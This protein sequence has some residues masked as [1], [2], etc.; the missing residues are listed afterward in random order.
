MPPDQ[1]P[2]DRSLLQAYAEGDAEAFAELTRRTAGMV[3]AT[4][5]RVLGDAQLA[6]DAS[7][8]TFLQLMRSC[9][10]VTGCVGAWLHRVATT[11]ALDLARAE[12]RRDERQRQAG[13]A[14]EARSWK[15]IS[16]QVDEALEQLDHAQRLLLVRH[17]L[18]GATQVELARELTSSQASI[19]RQLHE[20]LEAIRTRLR[21]RGVQ[22]SAALLLQGWSTDQAAPVPRKLLI[23]LGKMALTPAPAAAV[24]LPLAWLAL[25]ALSLLGAAS[26]VL[27]MT[28]HTPPP[29]TLP[30]PAAPAKEPTVAAKE[31]PQPAPHHELPADTSIDQALM[32]RAVAAVCSGD[33]T[34]LRSL[35]HDHPGLVRARVEDDAGSYS[36]YFHHATLLHHC[37]GNPLPAPVPDNVVEIARILLA[38]GADVD[39]HTDAGPKQPTDP[40]WT[41]L[42]LVVSCGAPI[43]S[44]LTELVDLLVASGANLDDLDGE[45]LG[46]ALQY[47]CWDGAMAVVRHGAKLDLLFAAGMGDLAR[48][49]ACFTAQ[50]QLKPDAVVLG[51]YP[52]QGRGPTNR[53]NGF[54]AW[55]PNSAGDQA[56]QLAEALVF[57]L[58]MPENT[59][60][61][62]VVRY[63][64]DRGAR[65]LMTVYGQTALHSAAWI[66]DA[67]MCRL[68]FAHGADAAAQDSRYHAT[69]ADWADHHAYH[70]CAAMIRAWT[71]ASTAPAPHAPGF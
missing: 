13:P 7:Q 71:P 51:G 19:S 22:A 60:R 15:D 12:R 21:Q 20:A 64:L 36:G 48:V 18:E 32:H 31:P 34:T 3:H 11:K 52:Q 56:E 17:Y 63:L 33:A 70:A 9:R 26:L 47:Q 5:L 67:A 43:Q 59:H 14:V 39:A 30:A 24:A 29:A 46:G 69:A 42:A 58:C 16:E 53:A 61:E 37:A 50:G 44:H 1:T 62:A 2:S 45:V 41:T 54:T 23:E 28:H 6:Q 66:N 40:G 65:P 49:Q 57:A 55:P 27:L 38:A 4:C 8:E 68:L 25:V 35:L 10:E